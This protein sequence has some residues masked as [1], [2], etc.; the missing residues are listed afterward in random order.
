MTQRRDESLKHMNKMR[1]ELTEA[2]KKGTLS[3]A[4]FDNVQKA[5]V[6]VN[7]NLPIG[8]GSDY[9]EDDE[10][11]D[12]LVKKFQ[13]L[14]RSW[15]RPLEDMMEDSQRRQELKD[16]FPSLEDG[17]LRQLL[18]EAQLD[19]EVCLLDFMYK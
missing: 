1:N 10:N 2:V 18:V 17:E 7:K 4:H 12:F 19:R 15:G 11:E 9:D 13:D 14:S 3:V 5:V 16:I 6:A 8:I